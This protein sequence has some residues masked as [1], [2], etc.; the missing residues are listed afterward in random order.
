MLGLKFW[1]DRYFLDPTQNPLTLATERDRL[2]M[3]FALLGRY[4]QLL[5]FPFRL[6]PDYGGVTIGHIARWND[7]YLWA[8][9]AVVATWIIAMLAALLRRRSAIAFCMLGLAITY[10]IV[11]NALAIIGTIFGERLM[12]LP[13][14]FLL[15][16]MAL[17]LARMRWTLL[18]PALIFLLSVASLRSFTY[19]Q[20]WNDPVV[21]YRT[22]LQNYPGSIGLYFV[23]A[24]EL[25]RRQQLEQA[26]EALA[27]AREVMPNYAAAWYRSAV[28]S[29]RRGRFEEAKQFAEKAR[30]I[31]PRVTDNPIW[32]YI[33]Q[34][35]V[36]TEE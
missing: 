10:A 28:V 8:G 6:S 32:D 26:A 36:L 19:A 24:D 17:P 25:V 4:T 9:F 1:W 11:G 5:V 20:R 18:F 31:D 27:G 12:Y 35:R 3:A 23:L 16:A 7:P 33:R 2:L 15:I 22:S 14:A 30:D 13:S 29:L 34:R 21:L